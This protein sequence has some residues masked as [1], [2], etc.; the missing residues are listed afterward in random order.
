M[1]HLENVIRLLNNNNVKMIGCSTSEIEEITSQ[2]QGDFPSCY[3][4]FLS[5]MGI[6]TIADKSKTD[7]NF[8]ISS[9]EGNTVFYPSVKFLSDSLQKQLVDEGG[10]LKLPINAFVFYD[11]QGILNAIFKL[12]DG[13]NPPVYGYE[14]GFEG[15]EFPK[16]AYLLSNFYER[17]LNNDSTLFNELRY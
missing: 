10:L 8:K 15:N 16:I 1:K 9:F 5:V 2:F 14:E 17:Y 13:N 3:I 12:G 6:S 7:N 11:S 4:E